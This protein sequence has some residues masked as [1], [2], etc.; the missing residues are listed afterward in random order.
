MADASPPPATTTV[1][2][3]K[4]RSFFHVSMTF[5]PQFAAD[6]DKVLEMK[7]FK[8]WIAGLDKE[9][10]VKSILVQS[11][12]FFGPRVGFLKFKAD[13]SDK[14]GTTVPSIVF[15]RGAAV[16]VLFVLRCDEDGEFYTILTVQPRFPTG[17]YSFPDIP[18]GMVD[19][20]GDFTGVAAKEMK[21]ETGIEVGFSLLII[22]IAL[23]AHG[24]AA[25][26]ST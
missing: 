19:G 10:K 9:F 18:A 17:K 16:A 13:V 21:E 12:D 7:A 24:C 11:V 23:K 2:N 20:N 4:V 6:A 14:D 1:R 26:R 8:D 15:M 5:P 22:R 25:N 3:V